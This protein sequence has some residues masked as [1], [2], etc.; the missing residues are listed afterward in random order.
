MCELHCLV[1]QGQAILQAAGQ[2]GY[3]WFDCA[4]HCWAARVKSDLIG[5]A[6]G[7]L[8]WGRDR[9]SGTGRKQVK[10]LINDS[11]DGKSRREVEAELVTAPKGATWLR[12][13]LPNGD[14]ISRK[15][16]RDV[17]EVVPAS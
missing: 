3:C 5:K 13:R 6:R 14:I 15:W 16:K 12:V 4:V 11:Y 8:E 7:V 9:A 2:V 1:V 10:V 17:P